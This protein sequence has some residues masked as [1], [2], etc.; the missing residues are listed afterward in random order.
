MIQHV[1]QRLMVLRHVIMSKKR[2]V[3]DVGKHVFPDPFDAVSISEEYSFNG[4]HSTLLVRHL[5][6]KTYCG[7]C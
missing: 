2:R 1:A 4:Q 6:Y 5:N 3:L 7:V